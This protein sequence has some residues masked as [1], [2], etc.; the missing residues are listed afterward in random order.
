MVLAMASKKQPDKSN[1]KES[2]KEDRRSR[3]DRRKFS[4][5]DYI[6]ERRSNEDRRKR[7]EEEKNK[8]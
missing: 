1:K 2:S 7:E 5:T 8:E 4:Y 6:P 3:V